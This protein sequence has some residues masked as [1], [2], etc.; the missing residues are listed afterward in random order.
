MRDYYIFRSG[1]ISRQDNSVMFCYK[2]DGNVKKTPIPVNN[3]DS[4]YIFGEID[5]NT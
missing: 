5:L 3:I 2:E 4:I 1:R